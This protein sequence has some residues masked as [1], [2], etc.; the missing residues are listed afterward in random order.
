MSDKKNELPP[1]GARVI[2]ML[3]QGNTG[4]IPGTEFLSTVT[5]H[6]DDGFEA[7]LADR[8]GCYCHSAGPGVTW[9]LAG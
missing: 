4:G 9:R 2:M 6:D 7:E 1:I 8:P 5:G 3:K